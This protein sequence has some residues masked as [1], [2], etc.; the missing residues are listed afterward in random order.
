MSPSER[1]RGGSV[2]T[3]SPEATQ[4]A[5]E[6][7]AFLDIERGVKHSRKRAIEEA[8]VFYWRARMGMPHAANDTVRHDAPTEIA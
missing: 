4:I 6:I 1:E 3:L 5:E 7:Q 2:T 8:I